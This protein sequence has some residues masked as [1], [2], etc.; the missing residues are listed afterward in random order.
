MPSVPWKDDDPPVPGHP[1]QESLG[2]A[3]RDFLRQEA[4]GDVEQQ[5][6]EQE[7]LDSKLSQPPSKPVAPRDRVLRSLLGL[8]LFMTGTRFPDDGTQDDQYRL[9]TASFAFYNLCALVD[10]Q[11]F[12]NRSISTPIQKGVRTFL[13]GIS[14]YLVSN[15]FEL[16]DLQLVLHHAGVGLAIISAGY[17][18]RH[19]IVTH[20]ERGDLDHW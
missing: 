15:V 16:N 1:Y 7:T 18:A 8:G 19:F 2:E 20:P 17:I 6:R 5:N 3:Y 10:E 11:A 14:A 13:G 12:P 4:R 9:A